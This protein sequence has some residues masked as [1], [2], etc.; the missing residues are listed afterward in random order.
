ML[1]DT[2]LPALAHRPESVAGAEPLFEAVKR[3]QQN[4]LE[5]L[6]SAH[7]YLRRLHGA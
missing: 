5:A 3:Q 7:D 6:P 4:L 2:P 1:P